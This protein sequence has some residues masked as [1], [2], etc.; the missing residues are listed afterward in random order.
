GCEKLG[1]VHSEVKDVTEAVWRRCHNAILPVASMVPGRPLR[2]PEVDGC[3]M[4][5]HC[6]V[7][8]PNP[9][10]APLERKAKRATNVSYVPAAVATGNCEIVP[11][12]FATAVLFEDRPGGRARAR[13]VR[14]RDTFTGDE[15]EAEASLVVLAG[16]SI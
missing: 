6:L 14:W 5:G 2:Y 7:G 10:G 9:V 13:G 16:G 8:C 15:R 12:A 3:T 11:N 4:C 1:L